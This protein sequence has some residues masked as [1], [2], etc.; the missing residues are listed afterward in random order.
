M[1]PKI[2]HQI[3]VGPN[4]LPEKYAPLV[5]KIGQMHEGWVHHLW[6]EDNLPEET[7]RNEWR[8]RLRVP[9][10]RSDLLR[11]ELLYK[12][13]G[14]YL[15]IDFDVLR[16]LEPIRAMAPIVVGN[17]K[18][19]RVNN[20]FI[21]AEPGHPI[22]AAMLAEAKPQIYHGLDKEASGS[23]FVDRMLGPHKQTD[24]VR[25]LAPVAFYSDVPTE[26]SFAV[27]LADRSWKDDEG[28]K[29]AAIRAERRLAGAQ[30]RI[31]LLEAEMT[32]SGI[33]V[34]TAEGR[35]KKGGRKP[36]E[37][38]TGTAK[39]GATPSESEPPRGKAAATGKAAAA[40]RPSKMAPPAP[41]K[42]PLAE[43]PKAPPRAAT[44]EAKAA[45]REAKKVASGKAGAAKG[46]EARALPRTPPREV[47][48]PTETTV[49]PEPNRS[50]LRR[51]IA[52][53]VRG[54][55]SKL[56]DWRAGI[57]GSPTRQQHLP[58]FLNRLGLTGVGAEINGT[59]LNVSEAFLSA[60]TGAKLYL[61]APSSGS[62]PAG[63][64]EQFMK[65]ARRRLVAFAGRFEV[66]SPD[67]PQAARALK[68]G[69]LDFV[70]VNG[71]AEP[72]ELLQDLRKWEPKVKAGGMVAYVC[73]S[74][75]PT[76]KDVEGAL[77]R[78]FA[79]RGYDPRVLKHTLDARQVFF[80]I[81]ANPG[82]TKLVA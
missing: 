47:A 25:L 60:W 68:E 34:P 42:N 12:L 39:G 74:D 13:G 35:P 38:G 50:L 80:W 65:K 78:F 30:E 37:A 6:T 43:P 3:W 14:F 73:D 53:V 76:R 17:L 71:S 23:L 19:R 75:A 69:R 46:N 57:F 82:E 22:I 15:D 59:R 36:A 44:R 10:E 64:P 51:G 2:I 77:R 79:E 49:R 27:H 61:L 66:L 11:L 29:E 33:N 54:T 5:A 81:K 45:T 18:E 16:S 1:I 8:E 55:R 52:T 7:I 41:A 56:L 72:R 31:R 63:D 40:T 24:Q 21:A 28:W 26:E 48:Q 9:A 32:R 67:Q 4:A 70:L 58:Q 20:A 62:T